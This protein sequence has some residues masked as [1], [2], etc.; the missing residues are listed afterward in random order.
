MKRF[1]HLTIQGDWHADSIRV[2]GLVDGVD[3]NS[4]SN[5]TLLK[6]GEERQN[7]GKEPFKLSELDDIFFTV[8][9]QV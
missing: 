3:I 7:F 1:D 2:A 9:N 6:N 4:W 5:D 8:K